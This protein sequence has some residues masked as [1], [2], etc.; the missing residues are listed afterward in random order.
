[1]P[2]P[3]IDSSNINFQLAAD[4]IIQT[5]TSVFL[6]GKAGTGKTTFLKYIKESSAKNTVIVAPTGVAAIN[7]GG[8]TIHSFFQLPLSPFIPETKSS[9]GNYLETTNKHSLLGRIR[10]NAEKR[11]LLQQLELLVID[12]ISM[13]RCDTLDAIDVILRSF[14]NRQHEP[15]GGVQ[16]LLIGDMFQLPPVI[17]DTEWSI[18]S[19]FYSNQYFFSSK[20]LLQLNYVYVELNKIYRQS[21]DIFIKVLNQ[22]RNNELDKEGLTVLHNRYNPSFKTTADDG[23]IILTTHNYKADAIN[24]AE[25]N[26]LNTPLITSKAIIDGEFYERSYPA[27]EN[28]QLKIGAQVM[29]IKNDKDK[30]KR[31]F[32]GKIGSVTKIENE[33]VFVQCKN[34]TLPIELSKE[35]WRNIRY[36]FNKQSQQV[37]EE[38]IGSF[39]QFPLRLA[40]AIT[41]HKSQGL[42][43]EKAVIDAGAAFVHGQVYV[44][45]SRCTNL[46]GIVLLSKINNHHQADERIVEF[47]ETYQ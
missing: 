42:T 40:W 44:A 9:V 31:F 20:A 28:L 1:M 34:E 16:L 15:F 24:A 6:T 47:L 30:S 45:L 12:E 7:A 43:F 19:Q 23:F 39:T 36:N 3:K 2:N 5:N 10:F 17:Q 26:K 27:E 33:T 38:E 13:V 35:T 4:Y 11:E 22:V 37:D 18:L 46:E 25:L 8:V 32:N 41:I 29:F 21:D 14:R